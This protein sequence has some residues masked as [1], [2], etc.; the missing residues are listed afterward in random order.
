MNT[1]IT[2]LEVP[3]AEKDEAKLLG[4]RWDPQQKKWYVPREIELT[5][6]GRWLPEN[7]I[8]SASRDR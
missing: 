8:Q 4:A 1:N 7:E 5:E 3:Y 2:Y 6:F